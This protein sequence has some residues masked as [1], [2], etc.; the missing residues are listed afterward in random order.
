[1][2]RKKAKFTPCAFEKNGASN[3]SATL[4]ASML[5][6]PAWYQLSNNAKVLYLYM[7]L[8]LYGQRNLDGHDTDCFY[9]NKS[10][11]TQTY[12]LYL[13]GAQFRRDCKQLIRCGFI[14]EVEN[15]RFSRTKNIYRFSDRWKQVQV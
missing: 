12:P 8:Q 13:N 2:G 10:M 5:Q 6:S 4:Y 7:K 11:Y 9:F 1:M 14:D 15:G 3:L